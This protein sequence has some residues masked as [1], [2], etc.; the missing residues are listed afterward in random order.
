MLKWNDIIHFTTKGN[1]EPDRKVIKTDEEWRTQ[2]TVEEYRV[3]QKK[4][5]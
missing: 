5:D 2:L 1:P 4:G 3:T